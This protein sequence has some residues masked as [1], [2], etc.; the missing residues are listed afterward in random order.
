MGW[1]CESGIPLRVIVSSSH[2]LYRTC[3]SGTETESVTGDESPG[4]ESWYGMA[5]EVEA[6]E[7]DDEAEVTLIACI[8][9]TDPPSAVLTWTLPF[10]KRL[11]KT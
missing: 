4:M 3:P 10:C 8:C 9:I 5:V 1:L 2:N 6:E 7:F 11:W